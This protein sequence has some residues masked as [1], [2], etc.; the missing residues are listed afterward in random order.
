MQQAVRDALPDALL[1]LGPEDTLTHSPVTPDA[2]MDPA[3]VKELSRRSEVLTGHP[4]DWNA[5]AAWAARDA[6]PYDAKFPE[7]GGYDIKK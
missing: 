6:E 4:L 7:R 3:Y 1:Y 5:I 2:Y